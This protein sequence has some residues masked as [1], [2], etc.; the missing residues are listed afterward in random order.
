MIDDREHGSDSETADAGISR[1][2]FA[3]L[4]DA[5]KETL[6]RFT[7]AGG[8]VEVAGVVRSS[9]LAGVE[10]LRH[11]DLAVRKS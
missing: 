1:R 9:T 10:V 5:Q 3:A 4:S 6:R 2:R 7:R 8:T 11:R